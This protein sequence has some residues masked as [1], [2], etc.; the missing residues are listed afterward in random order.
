M[1]IFL[2]GA[3]VSEIRGSIGG[4]TFSR[5]SHGAYSRNRVKPVDPRTSTQEEVRQYLEICQFQFREVLTENERAAW[6]AFAQST[7][8]PN[9]LGF[10]THMSAIN[11]FIAINV[12]RMRAGEDLTSTAPPVGGM[13]ALPILTISAEVGD[14]VTI[15]TPDPVLASDSILTV[16]LSPPLPPTRNYY[17]GPWASYHAMVGAGTFPWEIGPDVTTAGLRYFM[18][19]RYADPTGRLSAPFILRVDSITPP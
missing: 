18:K 6:Y 16:S 7:P 3:A 12:M 9:R 2:P 11:W 15:A 8:R 17:T 13:V 10:S 14:P 19:A 5:N 1:A 4:V